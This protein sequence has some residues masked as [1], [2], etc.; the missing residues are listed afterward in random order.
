M[1]ATGF[2]VNLKDWLICFVYKRTPADPEAFGPPEF[3]TDAECEAIQCALDV[4]LGTRGEINSL[5]RSQ[6]RRLAT[7]AK[8]KP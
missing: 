7:L 4:N 3:A 5:I 1:T 6:R 2:D 8:G